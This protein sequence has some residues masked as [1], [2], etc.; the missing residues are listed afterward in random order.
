MHSE[1]QD[2][3]ILQVKGSGGA[4]ATLSA[5]KSMMATHPE[6]KGA[7]NNHLRHRLLNPSGVPNDPDFST[8]WPL[9][10][11]RWINARNLYGNRQ[12]RP[13]TITI[14]S[15]GTHPV[16]TNLELGPYI[17]QYNALSPNVF[18]EPVQG[19][20]GCG[21][22]EGDIDA[23][24]TG[25]LTS[26]GVDISGS[27]CFVPSQPTRITMLQMTNDPAGSVSDA[28]IENA[29]IFA[30]D[31]QK[32]RGGRGP[33]NIS[34]G[35]GSPGDPSDP[36][37]WGEAIMQELGQDLL[38]QGDILVLAAGDTTGQVFQPPPVGSDPPTGSIVVVQAT[39]NDSTNAI[40][41]T[42]VDNDPVAAPGDVQPAIIGGI[43]QE[44]YFGSSFS[45][46]LWSSAIAMLISLNPNLTSAQAHQILLNT[47]T[48]GSGSAGNPNGGPPGPPHVGNF[49]IP[50]F[51][52]AIQ[53]AL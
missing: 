38:D 29:V 40:L 22:A 2:F 46:P 15:S 43:E 28:A 23:S 5:V 45:A 18:P 26:N 53:S 10:A 48:Q 4:A 44:D 1:T 49:Y 20:P 16:N 8:Q 9:A 52:R 17:K 39:A 24:I 30:L 7:T 21:G 19:T 47:G 12:V 36:P 33:V 51:D 37:L 31:N 13:A 14:C 34:Y 6:I 27:G 41:L 42:Q 35:G 11:M 32:K 3:S 50:A 25:A